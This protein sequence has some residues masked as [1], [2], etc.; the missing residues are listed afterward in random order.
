MSNFLLILL[1]I[2]LGMLFAQK[3]LV[4]EN[5][6]KGINAWLLNIALPAVSFKYLPYIEWNKS[7]IWPVLV[8]IIVW[9]GS[10]TFVTIY[11]RLKHLDKKT[12]AVL[13]LV[14]GLGN[15]SFVG[16]P[17]IMAWYGEEY[18][19]IGIICD[20]MSFLIFSTFGLLVVVR[21]S[22]TDKV[23]GSFMIKRLFTFPAFIG[24]VLALIL[25]RF[26]DISSVA[27]LFDKIAAT[28]APMALF[29]I[30][31]QLKFSG[32]QQD[33][34]AIGASLF[35]KLLLAPALILLLMY[36]FNAQGKPA[37]ISAFEATM[38][39][40]LSASIMAERYNVRP[41][42]TNRIIGISILVGLLTTALWT[43]FLSGLA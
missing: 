7:H 16:F 22:G 30:G 32:W 24:C 8:P 17:L 6:H 19:S 4:P 37:Q 38:P 43:F 42:L 36:A 20:Q 10:W 14:S 33:K 13:K 39:S 11:S 35:Y 15:T 31:L 2:G 26:I 3:K 12:T 1:C 34:Q 29:S 27:P 28:V 5:S 40:L 9:L 23:T 18:V 41:E 25:P 21:A